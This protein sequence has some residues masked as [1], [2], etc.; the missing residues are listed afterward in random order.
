MQKHVSFWKIL[1]RSENYF[2]DVDTH[3]A[4]KAD[5]VSRLCIYLARVFLPKSIKNSVNKKLANCWE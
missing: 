2:E 3:K 1:Y 5:L 4:G